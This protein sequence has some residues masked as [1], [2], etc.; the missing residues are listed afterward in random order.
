MVLPVPEEI[1][2]GG[3]NTITT[4]GSVSRYLTTSE[5]NEVPM[6]RGRKFLLKFQPKEKKV[7]QKYPNCYKVITVTYF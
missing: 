3:Y 2:K 4:I 7:H 6:G 5:K 1:K